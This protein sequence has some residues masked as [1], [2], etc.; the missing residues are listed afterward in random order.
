[1]NWARFI[2]WCSVNWFVYGSRPI[3]SVSFIYYFSNVTR[4][5]ISGVIGN[6][7]GTT[8]RKEY[9]VLARCSITIT[10]LIL[11]KV[12]T[13]VIILNSVFVSIY[14]RGICICWSFSISW[15]WVV[16]RWRSSGKS[17]SEKGG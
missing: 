16:W 8:I 17:N 15:S 13:T 3:S 7:L 5:G 1:M 6:S 12:Y 11:T 2:D 4:V 14:W 10:F 9:A